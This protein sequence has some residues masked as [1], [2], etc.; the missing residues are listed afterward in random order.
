M[1]HISRI[2]VLTAAFVFVM[3][4]WIADIFIEVPSILMEPII[5]IAILFSGAVI[6]VLGFKL[7]LPV[8]LLLLTVW[9]I[10]LYYYLQFIIDL[11]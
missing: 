5:Q 9:A 3:G 11:L 2:V 1:I 8:F 7:L 6:A 4:C 10:A